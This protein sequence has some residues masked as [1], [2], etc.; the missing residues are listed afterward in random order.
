[1]PPGMAL[2][3]LGVPRLRDMSRPERVFQLVLD[4]LQSEFPPLRSLGTFSHN[5]PVQ[6]T[7]FVGRR[8]ETEEVRELLTGMRLLTLT[9]SGGCGKSRLALQVAADAIDDYSGG[10]WFVGL[11]ALADPTLLAQTIAAALGI[12]EE[13]GH[14]LMDTLSGRLR[15]KPILLLLE[16]SEHA[17]GRGR[18]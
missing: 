1:M 15:E 7:S 2:L 12:Q 11:A 10:V 18:G 17:A 5:L 9:G 16:N 13:P 14:G 8:R 3:D 6:L 4:G